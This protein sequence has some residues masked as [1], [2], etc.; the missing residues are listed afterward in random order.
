MWTEEE[1]ARRLWQVRQLPYGLAR[2]TATEWIVRTLST[3]GPEQKL[4]WALLELV[5]AYT[6]GPASHH[7]FAS[8][9]QLLRM[10]DEHPEY[11]DEQDQQNLFWEFKWI[12]EALTSYPQISKA[13][14]RAML[15]DMRRRFALAGHS[16]VAVDKAEFGWANHIGD[17][18]A[19]E[20]WRSAWLAHGEDPMDC[21]ACRYGSLVAH[22][23]NRGKFREAIEVGVPQSVGCNREPATTMRYRALAFLELG[24]GAQA[25][26]HLLHAQANRDNTVLDCYDVGPEFE[27]LARG[28]ALERALRLLRDRGRPAFAGQIDP[29]TRFDWLISVIKGLSANMD[30]AQTPTS[31]REGKT[32]GELLTWAID[33][34]TP[35]AQAFDRRA[36]NTRFTE[37]LERAQTAK[38]AAKLDFSTERLEQAAAEAAKAAAGA[39]TNAAGAARDAAGAATT[40][41]AGSDVGAGSDGV[42]AAGAASTEAGVSGDTTGVGAGVGTADDGTGD[43]GGASDTA[44]TDSGKTASSTAGTD[45][46]ATD[47]ENADAVYTKA[48][49]LASRKEYDL[50]AKTYLRAA[51]LREEAGD[52]AG[53][54]IAYADCAQCNTLIQE[55]SQAC[56]LFDRAWPLLLVGDIPSAAL[57]DILAAWCACAEKINAV[58]QLTS[59]AANIEKRLTEP[60]TAEMI[61]DYAERA[62]KE[63]AWNK[64]RLIDLNARICAA[65]AAEAEHA[66]N[67]AEQEMSEDLAPVGQLGEV[68]EHSIFGKSGNCAQHK[69]NDLLNRAIELALAAARAFSEAGDTNSAGSSQAL[70]AQLCTSTDSQASQRHY[71]AALETFTST[72]N[73]KAFETLIDEY[74]T[75]LHSIGLDNKATELM[76]RL[77]S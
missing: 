26:L 41:T 38:Q 23:V 59:A 34:A 58:H 53:A 17:D 13:Q 60:D 24:D 9:S 7:G 15:D 74:V 76:A 29:G 5:E 57:I 30:Q 70:A 35:L 69:E 19:A 1:A 68:D 21:A 4:P 22:L 39:E 37:I 6:F 63:Y 52:L 16:S 62:S 64:A 31:I 61:G 50:A 77:F 32:V 49:R 18:A 65:V 55:F 75:Y 71:E 51:T 11:F 12:A 8:F 73:S 46:T 42:G 48:D 2:T 20:R 56:D 33:Q 3:D 72:R 14:A 10:W 40:K 43:G 66:G 25:A 47:N 28:G 54:G 27:I 44:G 67:G 36:E 45:E